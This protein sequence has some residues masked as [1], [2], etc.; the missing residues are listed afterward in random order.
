V[1]TSEFTYDLPDSA[2][3]QVPVE[4]RDAARL[5]DADTLE[6]YRVADLPG[7]LEPGDL[8]VVNRTRVRPARLIGHKEQT[9]GK[10]EALLLDPLGDERWT[11]LVR[12]ARRLRPGIRLVFGSVTAEVVSGPLGGRA[13]LRLAAEGDVETAIE[14]HGEIPLPPYV[15][16]ALEDPERYQTVF[17]DRPGSAAAPTAG[18]HLTHD[19]LGRLAKRGVSVAPVDL[20][21]GVDTFRPIS[22]DEIEDHRMHSERVTVGED[23]ATA[24]AA[25]R[26]RGGRVVALGTTV[27]RALETAAAQGAVEPFDGPTD[28][29]ITP[30]YEFRAVDALVTNF[31][32]PGSTLVVLIAAFCGERWREVYAAALAREYRFLSFG[33]AMLARRR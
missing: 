23:A 14:A 26:A 12:P 27:V 31:H 15:Q 6:D 19:V 33:D 10:V 22:T 2:I 21:I 3:A 9:G 13:V 8:L 1:K 32:V 29:F 17:A 7:L 4:P 18:L 16:A 20:R 5:L 28:L 11:A 30:G 25:A 24:V